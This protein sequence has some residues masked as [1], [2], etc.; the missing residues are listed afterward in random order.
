M[1]AELQKSQSRELLDARRRALM[2]MEAFLR[3]DEHPLEQR[4]YVTRHHWPPGAYAREIEMPAGSWVIGRIHRHAH[5]NVLSKGYVLVMTPDGVEEFEAPRTW[6][7]TPGTKRCVFVL[8]DCVWTTVHATT[9]RT[10]A[11]V[12][13]EIIA[14]D[15]AALEEQDDARP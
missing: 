1:S 10:V 4:D 14:P 5:V 7:S 15:F 11:E 12:E 8:E 6:V 9:K 2:D 3:G 13:A